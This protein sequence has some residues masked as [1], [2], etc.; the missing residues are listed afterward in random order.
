MNIESVDR[1]GLAGLN[2]PQRRAVLHEGGPLVVFAGAGSG[3]TRVITHR[4]AH[5]VA[6][7]AVAP[8]NILAVTFT[9]KAA[10]EM[11][12]RLAKLIGAGSRDLW[13]GTFHA[14]CARLLRRY[15]KEIGIGRD[16]SIYDDA[17]TRAMIKRTL[18]ELDLDEKRW[19]PKRVAGRIATEKQ[20]VRGPDE[21]LVE[22]VFDEPIQRVYAR[23]EEKMRA[24]NALDFGDLIYR[25]VLALETDEGLR[26]QLQGRFRHLLVDE[27]QDTNRAQY[28]LVRALAAGHRQ[29]MVVGDDDQSI[30]Y[31]RGAEVGNILRFEQDFPGASVIRLERNYRST[32]HILGA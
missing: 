7:R 13:V 19:D 31:W 23:Y 25:M 30:Y 17:D 5:L 20:E 16:F 6:E 18:A 4:V 2:P 10:N 29:V 14:T 11:R 9:N 26:T 22:S 21:M 1:L 8:W 3:K 27:F 24:A 28:R 15:A 32:G 12:E